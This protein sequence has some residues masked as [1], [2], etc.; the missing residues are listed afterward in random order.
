[1]TAAGNIL[2]VLRH[3]DD[4]DKAAVYNQLRQRLTYQPDAKTVI[5]DAQPSAIMYKRRV[6]GPSH[7][8]PPR[9]GLIVGAD[10][11]LRAAA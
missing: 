7:P 1:M 3:A 6:R 10:L 9:P 2:H 8:I 5:A 11:V 4:Q